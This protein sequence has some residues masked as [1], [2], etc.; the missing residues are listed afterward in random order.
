M[1]DTAIVVFDLDGV[2]IDSA[3]ANVQAFRY[4]LEQ[5]GV[6]SG[7]REAILALVGLPAVEMLRR[8]GCPSQACFEVFDQH[9]R[10]FYLENLPA[11][12]KAYPGARRVLSSLRDSGFRLAAC[13]SGDRVT[14]TAALEAIGLWEFIE[15]MQTPCDSGFGKPDPRYLMELLAK[16]PEGPRLHH[17]EDS[18]VGILMGRDC[19]AVTF[20]ASYGNG[21]LSGQ[22]QPDF[23]LESIEDLPMAILKANAGTGSTSSR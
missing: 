20:F 2:L 10:P 7:E 16:F 1:S 14:Q 22:V 17:V 8:L 4:G 19:G 6:R 13:T 21:S 23:I 5:V 15:E 9:V 18:E 12:A 11:L 3:E